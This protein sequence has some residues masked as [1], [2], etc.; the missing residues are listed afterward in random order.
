MQEP[1]GPRGR[2][3]AD[4]LHARAQQAGHWHQKSVGFAQLRFLRAA[5]SQPAPR[6]T[7]RHAIVACGEAE[8]PPVPV[9]SEPVIKHPGCRRHH[10][11]L[12]ARPP[13][14]HGRRDENERHSQYEQPKQEIG[15]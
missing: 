10:R 12:A 8:V 14:V 15:E 2:V 1:L 4:D 9:T 3:H 5:R 7:I 11:V 6:N 13:S